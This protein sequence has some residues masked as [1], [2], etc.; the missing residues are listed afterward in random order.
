MKQAELIKTIHQLW[1][2]FQFDDSEGYCCYDK[3][4]IDEHLENAKKALKT[5]LYITE[6]PQQEEETNGGGQFIIALFMT[7]TIAL[8][9]GIFF[10]TNNGQNA[11]T[12]FLLL[13]LLIITA[14]SAIF[15]AISV[16]ATV[17]VEN[18]MLYV[19]D[20]TEANWSISTFANPQLYRNWAA[21]YDFFR[22][23]DLDNRIP[24]RIYGN[25]RGYDFCYFEYA[26]TEIIENTY[27]EVDSD[28]NVTTETETTYEEHCK[29]GL[30]IDS[31]IETAFQFKERPSNRKSV[32]FSHI[33]F[34]KRFS[35]IGEQNDIPLRRLFDPKKRLML[36][37]QNNMFQFTDTYANAENV[38]TAFSEDA[39]FFEEGETK[40]KKFNHLEIV[41]YLKRRLDGPITFLQTVT[42]AAYE[43]N[44]MKEKA[45]L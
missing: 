20:L 34:E 35:V 22:Q 28:G 17:K 5:F 13:M 33:A 3:K 21:A 4:R 31:R 24:V 29:S 10:F 15:V 37:Q 36:L 9:I 16:P 44:E 2:Q 14:M 32:K 27:D 30:F 11:S 7:M 19:Y 43:T 42:N 6:N 8:V 40:F 26:Y 25:Y 41:P 38:L 39:G 23:G 12:P 1:N 45:T 18:S